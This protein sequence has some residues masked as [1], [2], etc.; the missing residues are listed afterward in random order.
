MQITADFA[1]EQ[2]IEANKA[3][4]DDA[5]CMNYFKNT[6][7]H[8]VCANDFNFPIA[9]LSISWSVISLQKEGEKTQGKRNKLDSNFGSPCNMKKF[10]F[11]ILRLRLLL[12]CRL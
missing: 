6:L 3:N 8:P 2:A 7:L 1:S 4:F 5:I 10:T 9:E 12:V 11:V